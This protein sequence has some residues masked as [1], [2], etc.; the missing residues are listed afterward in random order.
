V[1]FII[2]SKFL[3]SLQSWSYQLSAKTKSNQT[4]SLISKAVTDIM[5]Q[6][7]PSVFSIISCFF[8]C[9]HSANHKIFDKILKICNVLTTKHTLNWVYLEKSLFLG[10]IHHAGS[11]YILFFGLPSVNI[12]WNPHVFAPWN[13]YAPRIMVIVNLAQKSGYCN[14]HMG[15]I[16]RI[17]HVHTI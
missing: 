13:Q 14:Y 16:L 3:Q 5:S 10:L 12:Q 6:K 1:D 4:Y 15:T 9:F 17:W 8:K 7:F 11:E 2:N